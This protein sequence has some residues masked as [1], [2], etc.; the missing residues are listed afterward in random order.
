MD[1]G[2]VKA[3]LP[4]DRL[5]LQHGPIDL[6]IKAEGRPPSVRGAYRLAEERFRTVLTEL[7]SEL[8]L[9]RQPTSPDL[10]PET[11][12]AR[13]MWQ[14][15][16]LFPN[17][18]IT[19]M[20]AVAGS[21]ADEMI[22]VMVE[23]TVGLRKV[24]VNNGGDIALWKTDLEEFSID[25]ATYPVA[26]MSHSGRPFTIHINRND[27]IGGVATSGRHGRSFSLGIAD[28]VTVLARNAAIADTCAT[29][30]ANTV[31]IKSTKVRRLPANEIE[32]DS[33]LGEQLVTV[34]VGQLEQDECDSALAKGVK[35]AREFLDQGLVNS[36]F[37][38][39]QGSYRFV[40]EDMKVKKKL[41]MDIPELISA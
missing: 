18:F 28:A 32:L 14:A 34:D 38:F 39:L 30:I 17:R 5:H 4:G 8:S 22:N 16:T 37:L 41:S 19:P 7:V 11:P 36:V 33:D 35:L 9:L 23:G 40:S 2:P 31:D 1:I 10:E 25:L 27:E 29:L 15:T 24:F 12:V 20:G 13:R 3:V 26:H 6:V 21:V